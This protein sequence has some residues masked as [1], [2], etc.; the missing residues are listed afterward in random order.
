MFTGL[1]DHTGQIIEIQTPGSGVRLRIRCEFT[2][3]VEGESIS[4]DGVCLTAINTAKNEFSCQLSPETLRLTTFK[5]HTVGSRVNLERSLRVGDRLGG[6]FVT[7]HADAEASVI[8][9]TQHDDFWSVQFRLS[10][11]TQRRYLLSKGS[12]AVNGVSLTINHVEPDGFTVMLIPHTLD[13]T[14]LS[15]LTAGTRVN[16]EYD[17]L[18]KLVV[19]TT[20]QVQNEQSLSVS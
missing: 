19:N 20:Q 4:T 12:V 2:D 10:D 1:I 5:D 14:N 18:A 11:A 9:V 3:L 16:I 13:R 7:G 6:H 8:N 15:E 17:M